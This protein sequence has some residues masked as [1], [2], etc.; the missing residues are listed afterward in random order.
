MMPAVWEEAR[1]VSRILQEPRNFP[2]SIRETPGY[3]SK[4]RACILECSFGLGVE[5]GGWQVGE[6]A[7]RDRQGR[8]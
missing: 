7:W 4:E 3:A 2:G 8:K 5:G 1:K 6:A